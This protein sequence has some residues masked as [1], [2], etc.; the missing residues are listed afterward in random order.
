MLSER[1]CPASAL[2]TPAPDGSRRRPSCREADARAVV[3]A[4]SDW[5]QPTY[6]DS[7]M[8]G[9]QPLDDALIDCR[10]YVLVGASPSFGAWKRIR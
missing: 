3:T 6:N 5:Y 1:G 10:P 8:A 7:K 4:R 2:P 9:A